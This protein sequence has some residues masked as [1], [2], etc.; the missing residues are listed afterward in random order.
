MDMEESVL[1]SHGLGLWLHMCPCLPC[2]MSSDWLMWSHGL[3]PLLISLPGE[4]V[5]SHVCYI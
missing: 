2:Q 5:Q 3:L 1:D 4:E